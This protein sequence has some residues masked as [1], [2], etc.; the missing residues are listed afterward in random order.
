MKAHELD[1][2]QQIQFAINS[3]P[4][5]QREACDRL[6]GLI[7]RGIAA[8]GIVAGPLALALFGAR[9]AATPGLDSPPAT[10]EDL[11]AALLAIHRVC[12]DLGS[13]G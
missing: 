9:V 5:E 3:L 10:Q 11:A 2:V 8:A 4:P 13:R 1:E 6:V 7:A 12:S